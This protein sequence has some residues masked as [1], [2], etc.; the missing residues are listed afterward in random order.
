MQINFFVQGQGHEIV[1]VQIKTSVEHELWYF[2][3]PNNYICAKK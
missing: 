3:I 2:V 1:Q